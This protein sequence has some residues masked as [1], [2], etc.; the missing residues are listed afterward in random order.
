MEE[1]A[2]RAFNIHEHIAKRILDGRRLLKM[3]LAA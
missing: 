1:R 2:A 3:A